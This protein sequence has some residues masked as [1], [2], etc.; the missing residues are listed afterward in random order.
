MQ[1]I[2]DLLPQRLVMSSSISIRIR[3]GNWVI[4][5]ENRQAVGLSAVLARQR[6]DPDA[7]DRAERNSP[8]GDLEHSQ[9]FPSHLLRRRIKRHGLFAQWNDHE[10][11]NEPEAENCISTRLKKGS[12]GKSRKE[13]KQQNGKPYEA[14]HH[15]EFLVRLPGDVHDCHYGMNPDGSLQSFGYQE[16]RWSLEPPEAPFRIPERMEPCYNWS[17]VESQVLAATT[18]WNSCAFEPCPP[19]PHFHSQEQQKRE[20]AYD[21][22]L[23]K[24]ELE[25]KRVRGGP[26]ERREAQRR[27]EGVFPRFASLALG[28]EDNAIHMLTD[29]FLPIG[30]SFAQWARRFDPLLPMTDVIQACRNAWTVCGIQP[31]LGDRMQMTPAIIGYS[32]LYPYSDNYLD[33]RKISAKSKLEFSARFRDRLCG[34]QI[35]PRDQHESAVWSMVS[36]IEL[37]YPRRQFPRV[38]E[39]LLA[40]HQ[41]QENSMAQLSRS[42]HLSEAELLRLSCA[43]GGTSVLADACLSHGN[44]NDAEARFAFDWGV[45][46]QLGDDLQDVQEDLRQRSTTLFSRAAAASVPLDSLVRQ[47]LAFSARVADQVDA[48]PH[49]DPALKR[50][51]RMSWRSLILMAVAR[52]PRSFTPAFLAELEPASPFRFA[53]LRARHKRLSGRRGLYRILFE[54]FLDSADADIEHLPCPETWLESSQVWDHSRSVPVHARALQ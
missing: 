19:A 12:V 45:L 29:E 14:V 34:L 24:V 46:L 11:Q 9:P 53:F 28:L 51:L 7:G 54:S 41:A 20:D 48:L 43:K 2:Q 4:G 31:L 52:S 50:L 42:R 3:H 36:L 38:Y 27:I 8:R 1:K 32:L 6:F 33:T 26:L 17:W 5:G 25:A 23:R 15:H 47:L 18:S 16:Y 22:A 21:E 44:L 30:T 10:K 13:A 39:S 40:I 35:A 37:E 49:G